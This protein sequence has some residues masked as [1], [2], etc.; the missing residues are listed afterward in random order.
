MTDLP[1]TTPSAPDRTAKRL[2]L[3]DGMRGLAAIGVVLFHAAPTGWGTTFSRGYLFVDLFFLLSGFV[4]ARAFEPRFAGGL[5]ARRFLAMRLRR[6]APMVAVG[7]LLGLAL[8]LARGTPS[9]V[10]LTAFVLA[11]AMVPLPVGGVMFPLNPPQW[12]LLLELVANAAHARWLHRLSGKAL[13]AIAAICA[14]GMTALMAPAGHGDL[15]SKFTDLPAGL[16]RAGWSYGL[17]IVLARSGKQLAGSWLARVGAMRADWRLALIA[18]LAL[19]LALPHAPLPVWLGDVLAITCGFPL[20]FLF[21][22][23]ARPAPSSARAMAAL[24]ALS[25]PLYAVHFPIL[26]AVNIA[27]GPAAA[28]LG[29]ASALACAALL[30]LSGTFPVRRRAK[31]ALAAEG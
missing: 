12:S 10:A 31:P 22:T 19:V 23:T 4:L 17:G 24:G 20:L 6:F 25:F 18:P 2:A 14:L 30:A 26:L 7:A 1:H 15:G 27:G 8:A 28:P 9:G 11:L 16:L 5:G 3:L 13:A 21:A 29:V